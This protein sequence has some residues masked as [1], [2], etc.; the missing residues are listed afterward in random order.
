MGVSGSLRVEVTRAI[1]R[2]GLMEIKAEVREFYDI[3]VEALVVAIFEGEKTD[4]GFLKEL[5]E[6]SVQL[7]GQIVGSEEMR[8]RPSDIVYIHQPGNIR[9]KRLLLVGAG[10]AA[11]LSLDSV[12]RYAAT[13]AR[14]LRSKGVRSMALFRRSSLDLE[15]DA[16]EEASVEF[17]EFRS[18]QQ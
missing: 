3:D 11:N 8:G 16:G 17:R 6:R 4:Q 7:L 14:F 13:A 15:P 1:N 9:S 18:P 12:S 2:E 10:K 5:D